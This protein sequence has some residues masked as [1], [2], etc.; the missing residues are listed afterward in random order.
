MGLF[1][2]VWASARGIRRDGNIP[3]AALACA[4]CGKI[5]RRAVQLKHAENSLDSY[6]IADYVVGVP[7]GQVALQGVFACPCGGEEEIELLGK[8][9]TRPKRRI[10]EC[11]VHFDN[12]FITAVTRERSVEPKQLSWEMVEHLGRT[13]QKRKW[14]LEGI[15]NACRARLEIRDKG[16]PKEGDLSCLWEH[17]WGTK[18]EQELIT[19]ILERVD[20]GLKRENKSVIKDD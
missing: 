7:A 2:T 11:W 4:Y 5:E 20:F 8:T 12:G 19:G 6:E 17:V 9:V 16:F 18:D 3:R 14:A 15:E 13:A 1:D 10:T